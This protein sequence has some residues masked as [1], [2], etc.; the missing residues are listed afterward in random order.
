[1]K[2]SER[3]LLPMQVHTMAHHALVPLRQELP[4]HVLVP[5]AFPSKSM[6]RASGVQPERLPSALTDE[7]FVFGT[8]DRENKRTLEGILSPS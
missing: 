8:S 4:I 3:T 5:N 1:M 2:Q 7:G 6:H